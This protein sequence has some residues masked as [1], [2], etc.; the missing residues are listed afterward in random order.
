LHV[1]GLDLLDGTPILDI[2]P[3]VP[4]IDQAE[5][6]RIGWLEGRVAAFHT[7]RADDRFDGQ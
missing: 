6:D 4:T 7:S 5:A 2:K 1:S 3:Y